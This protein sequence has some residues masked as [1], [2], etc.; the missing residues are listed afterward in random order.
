[1][2]LNVHRRFLDFLQSLKNNFKKATAYF[3]RERRLRIERAHGYGKEGRR[4]P[5]LRQW[6]YVGLVL[7]AKEKKIISVLCLVV[8]LALSVFGLRWY[9]AHRIFV[10]NFGGTYAEGVVGNPRLINPLYA[11]ASDIDSDLTGL[12]Y[13][14]LFKID[15]K[16]NPTP[17]LAEV[18]TTKDNGKKLVITLKNNL[19]WSSGAP[20]K[21]SDV[22]F[23]YE[24]IK[25]PAYQSP[26]RSYFLNMDFK[27][28]DD[29]NVEIT[30]NETKTQLE[31]YLTLGILPEYIWENVPPTS[32]TLAEYNL[33]PIGSGPYIFKSLTKDKQGV[34]QSYTLAPSENYYARKP[35]LKEVTFKF[36]PDYDKVKE[37]LD[38]KEIDGSAFLPAS[39]VQPFMN[40]AAWRAYQLDLPQ[41]VALFFNPLKKDILKDR[42]MREALFLALDREIIRNVATGVKNGQVVNGPLST[43]LLRDVPGKIQPADLAKAQQLITSLGYQLIDGKFF[44]VEKPKTRKAEPAKTPLAITL[45]TIDQAEYKKAADRIKEFWSQAGL[46]VTLKVV[47]PDDPN[48]K[49]IFAKRDFEVL[50]FGELLGFDFDPTPFWHSKGNGEKGLNLSGLSNNDVDKLLETAVETD[51]LDVKKQKYAAFQQILE[52]DRVAIFLWSPHYQY[53][54][55]S[56]IKG[57]QMSYLSVPSDRLRNL[58]DWY[59]KTRRAFK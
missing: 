38:S 51:S 45:T 43:S 11:V 36:Y 21:A 52:R 48:K 22:V 53:F 50:L 31:R 33:K 42:Q 12:I 32:A 15:E 27:A 9:R 34:V 58:P 24:L 46:E 25:N 2:S 41:Y 59:Q 7:G 13:S 54:I 39:L 40:R 28:L 14:G 44:K 17:D 19:K 1:M 6:R 23:T 56:R 37:A 10:P 47:A 3:E 55:D 5:S 20:L 16:G 49:D 35:Y 18:V 4:F 26:L 8:A 57:A 29:L 30:L